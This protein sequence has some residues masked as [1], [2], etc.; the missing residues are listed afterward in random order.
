MDTT[1]EHLQTWLNANYRAAYDSLQPGLNDSEIDD[2]L[3]DWPYQLSADVR[4][5]Y[6]WRNGFEDTQ[7]ELLPGLSFLP[8]E[9]ALELAAAYWEA[10]AAQVKKGGEEFFPRLVLPIFSDADSNVLAL[11]QGFEQSA[12][13]Q[14]ASPVQV[15]ALQQGQRLY[16][17]QRLE[18]LL[19]ASLKLLE[20]GVYRVDQDRDR[21]EIT[22]ERR[23]QA[24]WRKF[25]MLYLERVTL[26]ADDA[27][28]LEDDEDEDEDLSDEE[29]SENLLANLMSM[30]GLHPDDIDPATATLD[31]LNDLQEVSALESWPPALQ[32]R[33]HELGGGTK[34]VDEEPE[35][36]EDEP[37]DSVT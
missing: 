2:L 13:V 5:L 27:E 1:L 18:D 11:V 26:D 21:I 23:V 20:T 34:T 7:V 8:L 25:P 6:R 3:S 31:E 22:D 28:A 10:S 4:A 37:G 35:K 30:L 36:K 17:F 32:Q 19:K 14:P 24:G 9:Q 33:F 15:I 16:A 29:A 12:P